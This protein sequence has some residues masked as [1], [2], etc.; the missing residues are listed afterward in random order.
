M[1]RLS[2]LWISILAIPSI[3]LM[4]SILD[5]C[6]SWRIAFFHRDGGRPINQAL[7]WVACLVMILGGGVLMLMY[8]EGMSSWDALY[9]SM[10][11]S[12][13]VSSAGLSDW[14][15]PCYDLLFNTQVNI[16]NEVYT[17][18]AQTRQQRPCSS[19]CSSTRRGG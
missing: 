18:K 15:P 13:T 4:S 1:S 6:G 16:D 5:E 3:S 7:E 9:L 17:R 10:A 12:T 2:R 11:T 8:T 14:F 19:A